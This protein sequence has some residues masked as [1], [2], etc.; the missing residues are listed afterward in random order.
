MMPSGNVAALRVI[1]VFSPRRDSACIARAA[2]SLPTP[3]SPNSNTC[4]SASAQKASWS[5]SSHA[6]RLSPRWS[7]EREPSGWQLTRDDRRLQVR[8][9][10]RGARPS[11]DVIDAPYHPDYGVEL[12]T[13]RLVWECRGEFPFELHTEIVPA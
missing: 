2:S 11:L 9:S 10:G 8:V 1:I 7:V 6:T 12:T 5:R 13:R 3:L 4:V